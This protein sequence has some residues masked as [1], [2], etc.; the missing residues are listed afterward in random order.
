MRRCRLCAATRATLLLGVDAVIAAVVHRAA[1]LA[2]C[3]KAAVV[4]V[5]VVATNGVV[6]RV[7][8]G[9]DWQR[10]LCGLHGRGRRGALELLDAL[11]YAWQR[12]DARAVQVVAIVVVGGVE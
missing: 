5:A 6:V 12:A 11:L 2:C 1:A 10:R 7:A 4:V 8:S 9:A 3:R